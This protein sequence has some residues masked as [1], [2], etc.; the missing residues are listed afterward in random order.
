M[1]TTYKGFEQTRD[2]LIDR[3][4]DITVEE[5]GRSWKVSVFKGYTFN[6]LKFKHDCI[7]NG[8]N[9]PRFAQSWSKWLDPVG[10]G[11]KAF[12]NHD[13]RI[14]HP[15][16]ASGKHMTRKEIDG[17]FYPDLLACGYPNGWAVT[18][19]FFV[20]VYAIVLRRK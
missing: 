15:E 20:R 2:I 9:I 13:H 18:L 5:V 11:L 4:S 14:D 17:Y 8:G 16:H 6:G 7:T 12:I 10:P 3:T 19:W 1:I